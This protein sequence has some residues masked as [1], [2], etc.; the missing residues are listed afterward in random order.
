MSNRC[1]IVFEPMGISLKA[2]VGKTVFDIAADNSIPIRTDCGGKGL[3]GKCFVAVN[4]PENL[5]KISGRE[6]RFLNEEQ[7]DD[8]YR[9]ACQAKVQG[10]V[11]ITI[12]EV[13][14]DGGD[15]DYKTGISAIF[16][17]DPMVQRIFLPQSEKTLSGDDDTIDLVG[18][19]SQRSLIEA[20]KKITFKQLHAVRSLSMPFALRGEI[21]LVNHLER[22]ITA[23]FS[24]NNRRSLGVAVDIG[25]TTLAAY[26]CD[27]ATGKVLKSA[28][29]ANPQ[30]RYGEDVISRI[31]YANENKS[32]METLRKTVADGINNLITLCLQTV[33]GEKTDVDEV[34]IVGNTTMQQAFAGIHLYGLGSSPYFPACR[35][36]SDMTAADVGLDL[37]PGANVH[38]FPMISGFAGG[39]TMGVIIAELPHERDE[40]SLI[41]D[42]GTNGEIVL[43]NRKGLWA[44]SCATGPALEGAHIECGMRASPGAIHRLNIN[45]HSYRVSYEILGDPEKD[46]PQGLCGSA[47][48]DAA[49]EMLRA[50]ILLPSGRLKEGLPGV[51]VD[52]KGIGRKYTLVPAEKSRQGTDI[53]ITLKDIR[54]IQLA[55]GALAAGIKLLMRHAHVNHIDRIVLTGAF[56]ARFDWRNAV[57]IGMLPDANI[58]SRVEIVENAAGVG[59]IKALLDRKY[60][61]EAEDLL[62]SIRYLELADVK[63]FPNEF[64]GAMIFPSPDG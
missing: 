30:R 62:P 40:I 21:T 9:L 1:R 12:P 11:N 38:F 57:A 23:V 34:V 28:A 8:G 50:G 31:S 61:K 49:A 13:S 29:A 58:F 6:K 32:G 52:A 56:G 41:I 33:E 3:C 44:T 10:P 48:I 53:Y 15:G 51:V 24:G 18:H 14:I 35:V 25:T 22:G 46:F 36:I 47:I 19:F 5:S 64:A 42:I 26:L 16:T 43:G 54:Q 59:A 17:L 4:R 39:D 37:H 2:E 27:L 20:G 7:L 55:K 45:P 63:D 60:R